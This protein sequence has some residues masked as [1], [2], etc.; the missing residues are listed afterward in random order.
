MDL[1]PTCFRQ[2]LLQSFLVPE[3]ST[4]VPLTHIDLRP[5]SLWEPSLAIWTKGPVVP[6]LGCVPRSWAT[7]QQPGRQ[8]CLLWSLQ[9]PGNAPE[10]LRE[11]KSLRRLCRKQGF[12]YTS[13]LSGDKFQKPWALISVR[14]WVTYFPGGLG[15]QGVFAVYGSVTGKQVGYRIVPPHTPPC[16]MW[17]QLQ[18]ILQG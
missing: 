4:W 3:V 13:R 7:A 2:V 6:W 12:Y 11:A 15:N 16:R 9:F 17:V 5:Q 14:R 8:K 18:E 10:M 1:G